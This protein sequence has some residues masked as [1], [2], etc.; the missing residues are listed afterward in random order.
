[1]MIDDKA[2]RR[3]FHE[4]RQ[5][6]EHSAPEFD[7][8]LQRA[9]SA[10]PFRPALAAI[11]GLVI[12]FAGSTIWLL[13]RYEQRVPVL[14]DSARQSIVAWRAPTDFL[15]ETPGAELMWRIPA[16]GLPLDGIGVS[17]AAPSHRNIPQEHHT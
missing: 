2:I 9:P 8:L 4:L 17:P 5:S 10:H 16:I 3:A 1:M 12:V 13:H 11:A 14:A 6:T 15:L 7:Q